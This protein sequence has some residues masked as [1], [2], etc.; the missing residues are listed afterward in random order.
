MPNTQG[1]P[2]DGKRPS[3]D[4]SGVWRIIQVPLYAALYALVGV[5]LFASAGRLDWTM[6]WVLMGLYVLYLVFCTFFVLPKNPEAFNERRRWAENTKGWDKAFAVLYM[7]MPF[8]T[9]AVAG[10][11]AVR[12]GWSHMPLALSTLGIVM[13]L[14]GMLMAAWAMMSNPYF[15]TTVRIQ[16]DRGHRTVTSGPYQYVRHPGYMGAILPSIG[17][18]LL[19]GSW[20]A[21][22]PGGL[23]A[24]MF[25]VRTALEDRTLQKEL[26]GYAEYVRSVRYRLLPGVW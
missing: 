26:G 10:W 12:F 17:T 3:V 4:R 24:V 22:L 19:L 13:L 21:L 9:A 16:A 23:T 11:D 14:A 8:I 18:P 25:I 15:S 2:S 5:V 6:G 1:S 20:R 7:P